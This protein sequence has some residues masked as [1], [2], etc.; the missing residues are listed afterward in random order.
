M[1]VQ[2]ATTGINAVVRSLVK[3]FQPGDS[4]L[5]IDVAYGELMHMLYCKWSV[6]IHTIDFSVE[7]GLCLMT[8]E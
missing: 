8:S 7:A 4:I 3:K 1:F 6:S 2:N 5:M